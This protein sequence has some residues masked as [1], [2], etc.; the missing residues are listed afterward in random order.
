MTRKG[1]DFWLATYSKVIAVV[2]LLTRNCTLNS[3]SLAKLTLNG[4]FYQF[5]IRL[6]YYLTYPFR[7]FKMP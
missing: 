1:W 2:V 4:T 7:Y 5:K 3:S 6:P